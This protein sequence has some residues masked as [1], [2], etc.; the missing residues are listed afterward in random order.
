MLAG[1][2]ELIILAAKPFSAKALSWDMFSQAEQT[3]W[4]RRGLFSPSR[5]HLKEIDDYIRR[6]ISR[7]ERRDTVKKALKNNG[8]LVFYKDI[9]KAIEAI[10]QIA[11]EHMELI[12]TKKMPKE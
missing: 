1:P 11:P 8:F 6:F 2:T 12:G 7:N 10:N 5:D 3:K 4:P 9:D